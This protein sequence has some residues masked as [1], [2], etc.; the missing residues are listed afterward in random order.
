[1]VLTVRAGAF[2]PPQLGPEQVVNLA[3]NGAA[4]A[5][6]ALNG[7]SGIETY[8]ARIDPAL[9][10]PEGPSELTLRFSE[11]RSPQ[12]LGLGGDYRRLGLGLVE[13]SIVEE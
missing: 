2:A 4:V 13:L 11:R 3:V 12:E 8:R 7:G 1:L 9:I 5:R 10:P 6:W